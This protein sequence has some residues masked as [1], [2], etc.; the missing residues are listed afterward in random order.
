V[1]T[2]ALSC[3]DSDGVEAVGFDQFGFADDVEVLAASWLTALRPPD[4]DHFDE[5]AIPEDVIAGPDVAA[6]RDLRG[7]LCLSRFTHHHSV[8]ALAK[9]LQP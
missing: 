1:R 6:Q 2:S 9:L 8:L 3:L 7:P 4:A 5:A